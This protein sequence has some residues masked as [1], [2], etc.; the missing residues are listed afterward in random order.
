MSEASLP[1]CMRLFEVGA[2]TEARPDARA[3]TRA[4][5][6]GKACPWPAEPDM[7]D[8]IQCYSMTVAERL[9]SRLLSIHVAVRAEPKFA[10]LSEV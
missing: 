9:Q 2:R 4:D 7:R 1:T 3:N 10:A 8:A 5:A 6:D